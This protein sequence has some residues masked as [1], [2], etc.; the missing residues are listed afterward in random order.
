[1]SRISS[2]TIEHSP[3]STIAWS[4]VTPEAGMK[5]SADID[6]FYLSR[7]GTGQ[8]ATVLDL[9]GNN[10]EAVRREFGG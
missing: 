9:D 5:L 8:T 4:E 3:R 7:V 6:E 1:L 10:I 2:R